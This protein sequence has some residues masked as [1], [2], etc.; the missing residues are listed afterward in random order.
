MFNSRHNNIYLFYI[1]T[2]II[3]NIGEYSFAEQT[4]LFFYS[5]PF[6]K[7]YLIKILRFDDL[8]VEGQWTEG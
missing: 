1:N 8:I 6:N 2:I 7:K 5:V 4:A 3:N